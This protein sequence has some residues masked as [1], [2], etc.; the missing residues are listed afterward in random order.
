MS[1]PLYVA[2]D[3]SEIER[4][5]L[6]V[7]TD[8]KAQ[9]K[10]RRGH[11]APAIRQTQ[12]TFLLRISLATVA[13]PSAVTTRCY[14]PPMH[15]MN[16]N[17]ERRLSSSAGVRVAQARETAWD[18]IGQEAV[19]RVGR[20]SQLKGVIHEM[21]I[22]EKRNLTAAALLTG[23]RTNLTRSANAKTVDLVTTRNGRVI[24]R[25][26]A[27]DCISDSCVRKVQ[28]RVARGQYRTSR[29]VG[30]Q[31]TVDKFK[32]SGVSKRVESSGV[33]SRATTRAA[34]NAGAQVPNRNLLLNNGLDIVGSAGRAAA[35]GA[36]LAVTSE[37]LRSVRD[38]RTGKI[39][40]V[41]YAGRVVATGIK[42]G[43]DTAVRTTIALG[44]KE[45]VKAVARHVGAS[46]LK[47]FAGSNPGTA[48]AFGVAE[49][50]VNTI[51]FACGKMEAK[52][53]GVC[54][55]QTVGSTGGA[56]GGAAA[57]AA[58]GSIIPGPGTVVGAVVG[59]IAGSIGGGSLGQLVGNGIVGK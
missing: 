27:K 55:V 3:L 31:E 19:K 38:L 2:A 16:G 32:A 20:G 12:R 7:K 57:G 17:K 18:Y 13:S 44:T 21:A 24:E 11:P 28:D 45:T 41:E 8:G 47:R 50:A 36:L 51:R 25:L 37:A 35:C 29:L 22:R 9:A 52:D 14:I 54:T 26:Q 30:T 43:V 53:Y 4:F 46:G 49:Q 5:V 39:N 10:R 15:T 58:I 34:D 40:G 33:S 48:V 1:N 42:T 23:Q 6:R 56:I 59:G